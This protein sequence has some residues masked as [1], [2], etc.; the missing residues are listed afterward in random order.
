MNYY[1][2]LEEAKPAKPQKANWWACSQHCWLRLFATWLH[3]AQ[4]K[5]ASKALCMNLVMWLDTLPVP[6]T[7]DDL[8]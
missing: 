1:P 6:Y 8:T 4:A 5:D 2:G 3:A 7:I